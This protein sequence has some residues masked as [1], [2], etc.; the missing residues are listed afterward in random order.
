M[1]SSA[2]GCAL[3][4][5]YSL[6]GV[7]SEELGVTSPGVSRCPLRDSGA[8][9]PEQLPPVPER[10]EPGSVLSQCVWVCVEG[11]SVRVHTHPQRLLALLITVC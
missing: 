7:Y 6:K 8:G 4:L 11:V 2:T 5:A 9:S 1:S 3:E 10:R